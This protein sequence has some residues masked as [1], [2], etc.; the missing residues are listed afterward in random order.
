MAGH[1]GRVLE[2]N[3]TALK[4]AGL[5]HEL[6]LVEETDGDGPPLQLA[7]ELA[8]RSG[9]S[10]FVV[11]LIEGLRPGAPPNS[12]EG[13]LLRA[14]ERLSYDRPGALRDGLEHHLERMQ[15]LETLATGFNGVTRAYALKS[16]REL[17]VMLDNAKINDQNALRL[18]ED[19]AVRIHQ[20]MHLSGQVR[21]AVIRES[22]A[23][24]YAT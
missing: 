23:I 13:H 17:L 24:D 8:K 9:E 21:I 6:G 18:C 19:L 22:R 20:E 3:A 4:R 14:A 11:S 2:L 16:G 1:M 7:A 15:N 5:Y 10:A 12:A